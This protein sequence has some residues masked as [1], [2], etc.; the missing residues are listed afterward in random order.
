MATAHQD[1]GTLAFAGTLDRAAVAGLWTQ[2][3]ASG[4]GL[5]RLDL[6]AVDAVDSAGLALL[7]ELCARGERPD[8]IGS[9]PGLAELRA[10]YRLDPD[11]AFAG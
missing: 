1:G 11:L 8:V 2:L 9:P 3:R 7:A 6:S 10:A 5:H 4:A